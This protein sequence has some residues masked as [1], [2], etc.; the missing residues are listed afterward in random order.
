[1]GSGRGEGKRFVAHHG[2]GIVPPTPRNNKDGFAQRQE[3]QRAEHRQQ[4]T[5]WLARNNLWRDVLTIA[6]S[7]ATLFNALQGS[8]GDCVLSTHIQAVRQA[9]RWELARRLAQIAKERQPK[10]WIDLPE[11][12]ASHE[13]RK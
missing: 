2:P 7:V 9:G 8:N 12:P 10:S 3:N 6:G 1:M 5:Q 13:M 11:N 4:C